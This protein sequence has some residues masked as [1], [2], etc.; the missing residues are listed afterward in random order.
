MVKVSVIVP[1]YNVE[2]Y[3]GRC[4]DSLLAQSFT[5]FEVICIDDG[6]T[7][8]SGDIC[9]Q[10]VKRDSRIKVHHIVNGGVSN[11]RNYALSQI[12]GEWYAFVDA[13]DWVEPNYL[14]MLVGNAVHND[15]DIAA[16]S[17]QRNTEFKMGQGSGNAATV[18]L[19]GADACISNF[20]CSQN[21]MQGMVWNKLYRT[22]LFKD[23][24]FD[25][26]VKVNEDCLYTFEVMKKCRKAC[27][28]GAPLYH[29]FF[30]E[31]SACHSK[32]VACDFTAA[33]VFLRLY[34]ETA[35]L[36]DEAV[37]KTLQKNYIGSVMKVFLHA[38]YKK[39]A[40]DVREA[41]NRCKKWRK[42]V[43]NKFDSRMKLKYVLA[44]YIKWIVTF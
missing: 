14:E 23:V 24:C 5:D 25:V 35:R 9:E 38:K 15:C 43:W 21:S 30:R 34:D 36:Q 22:E 8:G 39:K 11:A 20:I 26:H 31:D 28:V 44:F 4:L 33:N 10:Y 27:F 13:D 6:S 19:E 7:D 18:L 42:A 3:I 37:T 32:T 16:C 12:A 41:R 40:A 1:V 2:K 17:F 29:W